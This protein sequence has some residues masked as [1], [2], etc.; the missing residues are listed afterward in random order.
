MNTNKVLVI[1]V[2]PDDEALGCAGTIL[3]HIKAG[4]EVNWL[5]ITEAHS[6]RWSENMIKRKAEE[7]EIVSKNYGMN[8]VYKLGLPTTCLEH[9]SLN[10]R[11][12]GIQRALQEIKPDIVYMIN[13]TDVHSD[14]RATFE[15]V[16]SILKPFHLAKYGV[17]KLLC[18]ETLSSTDAAPPLFQWAFIPNVYIDITKYIDEKIRIMSLYE[19][20]DQPEPFPRSPSSIR[21]LARRRG[22]TIG[23]EYAEAFMLIWEFCKYS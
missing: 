14:H 8:T 6:P 2:H 7:V 11:I 23:V 10:E 21:A 16:I 5:I 17:R 20:E 1:S 3:S 15:A 18:Y 13:G 19:S 22:A 9:L 12:E 4:D